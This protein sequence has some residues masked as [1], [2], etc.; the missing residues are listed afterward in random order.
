MATFSPVQALVGR[1]IGKL[2][3]ARNKR[4]M[5][6][7]LVGTSIT[8]SGHEAT[9]LDTDLTFLDPE[10]I[11]TLLPQAG[12]ENSV[13]N[14]WTPPAC[15]QIP[16]GG[17]QTPLVGQMIP[18]TGPQIPQANPYT[19]LAGLQSIQSGLLAGLTASL[20]VLQ[21]GPWAGS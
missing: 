12:P 1:S 13:A 16:L 14:P 19:P 21:T 3:F 18:Q 8:I 5:A 7:G 6:I 20:V 9:I 10:R 11:T 4:L 15:P 17:Q 2:L